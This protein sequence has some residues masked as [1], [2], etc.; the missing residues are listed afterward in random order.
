MFSEKSGLTRVTLRNTPEDIRHCYR[1]EHIPEDRVLQP[2]IA[3]LYGEANQECFYS[4]TN[5]ECYHPEN[6]ADMF[7]ETSGLTK[8]PRCTTAEDIRHC[9]RRE[10][11][12]EYSVLRPSTFTKLLHTRTEPQWN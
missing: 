3:S 12:P 6:E 11:I 1:L 9:Y 10:N 5:V 2:Y 7:S 8:A 4:N